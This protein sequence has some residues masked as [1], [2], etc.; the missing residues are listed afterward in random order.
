M[1]KHDTQAGEYVAAAPGTLTLSGAAMR[2]F[3]AAVLERGAPFR[4]TARGYSMHPFIRDADVITVSPLGGRA[5]RLGEVVAFRSGEDRLV[6]HRVVAAGS[7]R[8]DAA[9]GYLIRG[10]NCPEADGRV[11]PEAVLGVV[12]RVERAGR[13]R[14]LGIGYES[15]LLAAL[16][17]SGVLRTATVCACLPRRAAGGALRRAQR[18][19]ACRR[20]LRRL[21]PAFAVVRAVPADEPELARR[22]GLFANLRP[23]RGGLDVTAF[24]ARTRG[25]HGEPG[26]VIG[27]VELVL[28]DS[29]AALFDGSWIRV[30]LVATRYRGMGVAEALM[31]QAIAAA[32][33]A[34]AD[35]VRLT[36]FADNAPALALYRKL[37]FA[38]G[39]SPA[40]AERLEA[41]VRRGGRRRVAL[42]LALAGSAAGA[43]A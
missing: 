19:P 14:R 7:A 17:R 21:R 30:T 12:T 37:G 39:G 20:V 41:E 32:R 26:R 42:R 3:L 29:T 10:D 43:G 31:R 2:E 35:E 18:A 23:R 28:R 13:S 9:A 6:V 8:G 1:Q 38:P 5:P 16:S 25:D 11:P 33:D 22:F 15:A 36:V 24:V 4:F 40:L 34:G 27:F